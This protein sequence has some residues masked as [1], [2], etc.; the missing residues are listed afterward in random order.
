MKLLMAAGVAIVMG[1]ID[2]HMHIGL[3]TKILFPRRI[4]HPRPVEIEIPEPRERAQ[5][6]KPP[7]PQRHVDQGDVQAYE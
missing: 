4:R 3:P 2:M 5:S 7:I 1:L 6:L